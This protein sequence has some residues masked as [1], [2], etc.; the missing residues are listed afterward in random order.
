MK[1]GHHKTVS[2]LPPTC[3]VA[4]H[5]NTLTTMF[6][7]IKKYLAKK[8]YYL[9]YMYSECLMDSQLKHIDEMVHL[10]NHNI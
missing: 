9:F 4:K 10:S 7:L 6:N 3:N 2:F 5:P 1:I 8:L